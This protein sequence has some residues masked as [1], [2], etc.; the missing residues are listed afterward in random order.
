VPASPAFALLFRPCTLPARTVVFTA[1]RSLPVSLWAVLGCL[2][3]FLLP[4]A[5]RAAGFRDASA[6]VE[7]RVDDLVSQLTLDE[8]I[9]LLAGNRTV[10][11]VPRLGLD[12]IRMADSSMGLR[13]PIYNATAYPASV[14]LAATWD[15]ELARRFGDAIGREARAR[16]VHIVLGPGFNIQRV[17]QNGR[18]FE[19]YSEDPL[20]SARI[21][22]AVV[23]GMQARGVVATVKHFAANNQETGRLS[24]D[25]RVS[26]RALRE[27]YLPA[28][29]AAVCEGGA[30]TVM[31]AYNRLNGAYCTANDWLNN[32][33]LKGEWQF[34]GA[35]MSDWN[36]THETLDAVRGGLDL[37]MPSNKFFNEAAL[38]PLLASGAITEAMID[39]KIRRLFRVIIANGFLDRPQ[40]EASIPRDDPA[41]PAVALEIMRRGATLLKNNRSVLPLDRAPGKTIVVLGPNADHVS[42]GGGS[43]HVIPRHAVSLHEGLQRIAGPDTRIALIARDPQK[44]FDRLAALTR[45]THPIDLE[46]R[47]NYSNKQVLARQTADRIEV[48]WSGRA[49]AEGVSADGFYA[50][51]TTTIVPGETGPHAF[52]IKVRGGTSLEIDGHVLFSVSDYVDGKILAGEADLEAGRSYTLTVGYMRRKPQSSLQLVWG[53]AP[54]P[55]SA[56]EI[57]QVRTADAAILN[58]GFDAALETEGADRGYALPTTQR[59]LIQTVAALN[60]HTIVILNSGGSVQTAGW[61]DQVPALLHAWFPGQEGGQ[62]LAEILFGVVNPS[63]KLPFTWEKRFEDHPAFGNFPGDGR[64]VDYDEGVFVGYRWFDHRAIEPRFPF[65]HGLSYT[66]FAY[67]DLKIVPAPDGAGKIVSVH[68]TNRGRRAGDEIVQLYVAPPAARVPRPPR[69]LKGFSRVSLA[70]GET[71]SVRFA[72]APLDLAWFDEASHTWQVDAGDYRVQVGASSRDLRL[73]G[74]FEIVSPISAPSSAR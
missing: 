61:I 21:A 64:E 24:I 29:R 11:L 25:V 35:L 37:E 38:R 31:S 68:V 8:K 40:Q 7:A 39:D 42:A 41:A 44:E 2:A 5:A 30:W 14:A 54:A 60:P 46:F 62:A 15:T 34:K 48:D 13:N 73:S 51:W 49:P 18:N 32:T 16:G 58:V 53:P 65:G 26:E 43:S 59:R 72:F 69:E 6:P 27:I 66:R 52:M 33:I 71:K 3:V 55:L 1:R 70:P 19:Y 17:P 20:L 56:A 28:F 57:E 12:R 67:S 36:A 47:P 50:K 63:G 45:F 9:Q 74:E 23:Q 22:V 4:R 10:G